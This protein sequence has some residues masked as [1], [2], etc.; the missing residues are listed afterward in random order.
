[1]AREMS[2]DDKIRGWDNPPP[3]VTKPFK[4]ESHVH[5]HTGNRSEGEM[6]YV[7][8]TNPA[9]VDLFVPDGDYTCTRGEYY[10]D[11]T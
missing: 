5:P 8:R 4:S 11:A 10:R 9:P 7:P 2:V 3:G 6:Q 1:M